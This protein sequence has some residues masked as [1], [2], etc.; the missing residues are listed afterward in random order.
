MQIEIEVQGNTQ[1]LKPIGR[2]DQNTAP[3]FQERLLAALENGPDNAVALDMSGVD[4]LSSIGLRT[5]MIA[6]KNCQ[7]NGTR[8]VLFALTPVVREVFSISRFDTVLRCF[9]ERG[10]A[11]AG[12][13]V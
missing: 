7:A 6:H 11:L 13:S 10:P 9:D 4:F 2:I 8:L 3:A 1:I 5:L 12:L